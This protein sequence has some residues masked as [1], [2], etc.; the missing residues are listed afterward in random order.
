MKDYSAVRYENSGTLNEIYPD[1]NEVVVDEHGRV[2]AVTPELVFVGVS[3]W[4]KSC[5]MTRNPTNKDWL[6]IQPIRG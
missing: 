2:F 3:D 4:L 5:R 6:D 1:C